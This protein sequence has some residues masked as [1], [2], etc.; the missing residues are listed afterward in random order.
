[1]VP[2][3][4]GGL[5]GVQGFTWHGIR[6]MVSRSN[7]ITPAVIL[8]TLRNTEEVVAGVDEAGRPFIKW[9]GSQATIVFNMSMKIITWF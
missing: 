5:S 7:Y 9:V 2:L 1:M 8:D 3:T 6:R 4:L